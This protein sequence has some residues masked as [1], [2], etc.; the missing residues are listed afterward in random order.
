MIE[1]DAGQV[2]NL[3]PIGNRPV[4]NSEINRRRI[5]NPPQVTNLPH[6]AAWDVR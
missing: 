3:R 2:G 5:A 1:I 6:I 4:S